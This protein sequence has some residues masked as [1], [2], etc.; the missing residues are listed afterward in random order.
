MDSRTWRRVT[1]C[2]VTCVLPRP[3]VFSYD[4]PCTLSLVDIMKKMVVSIQFLRGLAVMMVVFHHTISKIRIMNPESFIPYSGFGGAGVDI[5]FVI[6]GFI[7]WVTTASKPS[8]PAYF[9]YRRIIRVVPLYW[10][11]IFIIIVPKLFIPDLFQSAQLDPEHIVKSLLFIPHYHPV[12]SDQIWPILIPGWTLNYEMFFYFLFGASLF[13]SQSA[14]LPVLILTFLLLVSIGQWMPS[15]SPLLITYTDS[16]LLE[17]LAGIIIGVFYTRGFALNSTLTR[18]M[19]TASIILFV[20]TE[21]SILPGGARALTWGV[22]AILLVIATLSLEKGGKIS[23]HNS[24]QKIGD[25]SYSIYLSHILTIE[26][27]E[28]LWMKFDWQM[29]T[30]TSQLTFLVFCLVASMLVGIVAYNMIERPSL[31]LL[32]PLWPRANAMAKTV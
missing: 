6:S 17:F 21:T 31:K 19:L 16:L 26:V 13:L 29:E 27:V 18:A 23:R 25:A 11:F 24:L 30:V 32:R 9:W 7:M 2:I 22:P 1:T 15:D 12:V 28:L 4:A 20:G 10:F 5:F 3:A 14:R 8:S